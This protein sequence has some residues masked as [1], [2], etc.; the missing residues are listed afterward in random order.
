MV[1]AFFISTLQTGSAKL[2]YSIV[3][4]KD[5]SISDRQDRKDILQK[6]CS[7]LVSEYDAVKRYTNRND[8][9]DYE[10]LKSDNVLPEFSR[11]VVRLDKGEYFEDGKILLWF[12]AIDCGFAFVLQN[13]ESVHAATL[14]M[15][16]LIQN[17]Q[18]YTRIMTEPAYCILKPE[19]VEIVVQ[20]SLANGVLPLH[21]SA[22][23]KE[24]LKELDK[25]FSRLIK[26]K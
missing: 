26:E 16:L 11:G 14:N 22:M 21:T 4:D 10:R 3:F 8:A 2:L 20:K 17:L 18:Q 7:K 6:L 19:R 1:F 23:L 9:A 12:A 25:I 5:P 13:W 15:K 24:R